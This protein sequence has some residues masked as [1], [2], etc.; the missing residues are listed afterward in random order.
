LK[1]GDIENSKPLTDNIIVIISVVKNQEFFEKFIKM[2]TNYF[3]R[4]ALVLLRVVRV[5]SFIIN[6]KI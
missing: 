2:L 1:R 3:K 5:V 6:V 4:V